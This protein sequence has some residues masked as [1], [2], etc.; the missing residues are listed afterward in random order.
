V[1]AEGRAEAGNWAEAGVGTEAGVR[2][3][4]SVEAE[5][6]VGAEAGVWAEASVRTEAGG[7]QGAAI[8]AMV[9]VAAARTRMTAA[10]DLGMGSVRKQ[11]DGA[12]CWMVGRVDAA[13]QTAPRQRRPGERDMVSRRGSTRPP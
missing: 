1:W 5:A 10:T 11:G 6:G 12:G 7:A 3:V 2:A 9:A 8:K 4:A 13:V